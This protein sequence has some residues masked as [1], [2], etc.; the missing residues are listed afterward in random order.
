MLVPSRRSAGLWSRSR[1]QSEQCRA[2]V[3]AFLDRRSTP[4]SSSWRRE[5]RAVLLPS[6]C[7]EPTVAG[8]SRRE[9]SSPAPRWSSR[10][11]RSARTVACSGRCDRRSHGAAR[12][13]KSTRGGKPGPG[14]GR[15][16]PEA[17]VAPDLPAPGA[18]RSAHAA[19]AGIASRL[20]L[21]VAGA[22]VNAA[23]AWVTVD[24][25]PVVGRHGIER[26]VASPRS[27]RQI[28]R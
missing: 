25:R 17:A 22:G 7:P 2:D 23:H 20:H 4:G 28:R 19:P 14:R 18:R 26:F 9:S 16:R 1:C 12:R 3:V 10:M 5:D 27:N 24:G 13:R 11:M 6:G 15:R 8:L 21:G